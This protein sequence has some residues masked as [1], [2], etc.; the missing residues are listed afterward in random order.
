MTNGDRDAAAALST[1]GRDEAA[2]GAAFLRGVLPDRLVPDFGERFIRSHVLY[3]EFVCRLA[4]AVARES[5]IADALGAPGSLDEIA[6]RAALP[7]PQARVPID[8]MLRFLAARGWIEASG[9]EPDRRYRSRG[10][11]PALDAAAVREEQRQWDPSW[12]PAYALAETVAHDYPAFLRGRMTG[13][14][15]LFAPRRLRLWVDYFSNDNGLYVVNNRVGAVAAAEWLPARETVVLE[16]GA[17]LASG[18]EALLDEIAARGRLGDV[19]GYRFTEPVSAFLRRGEQTLRARYPTLPGVT[20][21]ALDMNR[22]FAEQ[23]VPPASVDLVYAVNTLHAAFDLAFTLG[24]VRR[25]LS[26]GGRLVIAECVP[27][28]DPIYADFVFNLAETFRAPRLDPAY[29]PHGGFL[30]PAHWSAAMAAAGLEDV[31]I[32]PDVAR[33]RAEVPDWSVAAIGATRP[34]DG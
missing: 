5:G 7:G 34:A 25:V 32:L 29:R 18:A 23:G 3:G 16:L 27:P 4:L 2:R 22:P 9:G 26:P 10:A 33:I 14:D 8:W 1:L 19:R 13:E 17:G 30:G 21:E 6:T 15:V 11:L 24:E 12:M 20:A 28:P 31:R